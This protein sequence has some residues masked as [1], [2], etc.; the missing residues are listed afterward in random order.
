MPAIRFVTHNRLSVCLTTPDP[1]ST[2]PRMK[3]ASLQRRTLAPPFLFLLSCQCSLTV[4][5]LFSCHY[6]TCSIYDAR[7]GGAVNIH[8]TFL[9]FREK[10]DSLHRLQSA[11]F[12]RGSPVSRGSQDHSMYGHTLQGHGGLHRR[13]ELRVYDGQSSETSHD[14]RI[15]NDEVSPWKTHLPL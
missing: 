4:C 6:V 12:L 1:P 15:Q 8:D 9:G 11:K 7:F 13:Y 14:L 10:G 2:R 3:A 5:T